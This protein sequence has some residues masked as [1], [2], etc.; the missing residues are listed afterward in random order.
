MTISFVFNVFIEKS[1]AIYSI[2][3]NIIWLSCKSNT[4]INERLPKMKVIK[5]IFLIIWTLYCIIGISKNFKHYSF[6]DWMLIIFITLIPYMIIHALNKRKKNILKETEQTPLVSNTTNASSEFYT[7]N[8]T[9][10]QETDEKL[11]LQNNTTQN[12]KTFQS[13][14]KTI[15]NKYKQYNTHQIQIIL[16]HI[17]DS[18]KIIHSTTNPETLCTRYEFGFKQCCELRELEQNGLYHGNPESNYYLSLFSSENYHN[19]ILL[20]YDKYM[21]KTKSEL[22]TERSIDNRIEKFWNIIKENVDDITYGK[23]RKMRNFEKQQDDSTPVSNIENPSNKEHGSSYIEID[24]SLIKI[25]GE[26]ISDEEVPYLMQIGYEEVMRKHGFANP[27]VLDLSHI[28]NTNKEKR[29]YT[30]LPTFDELATIP[31]EPSEINS[32]DVFFFKYIDGRTLEKPDIAQYWYYDYNLNYS[33]EIKKLIS[34]ELLV[35]K[36]VNIQK[37]KVDELKAILRHF[38]LPL[39]GRKLDLQNRIYDNIPYSDLSQYFGHEKHYFCSTEKGKQLINSFFDSATKNLELENK[40]I[41]LI[42]QHDFR[43]AHILIQ[44]FKHSTPVERQNSYLSYNSNAEQTYN[45][46]MNSHSFYYTLEKDRDL[47]VKIRAS[48]VF[49]HMYGSGQDNIRKIIKRIYLENGRDFSNDAK[50][51]LSHRLL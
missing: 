21:V 19:L 48:V 36:N 22:K 27:P 11:I 23:L 20:Y 35:L 17:N 47:E 18:Y 50:N 15:Q 12:L 5:F 26:T 34:N 37:L 14:N 29:E 28:N 38:S 6:I 9:T 33:D 41:D 8:N 51:I 4:T 32:T 49:C 2:F 10:I 40:C 46:I 13:Q 16:Q 1:G 3:N 43:G 45:N 31:P 42:L 7:E 39:S 30:A 25:D 44:D 24:N